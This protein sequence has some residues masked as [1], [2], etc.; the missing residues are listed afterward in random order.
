VRCCQAAANV[1][2]IAASALT[3]GTLRPVAASPAASSDAASLLM[4][5]R[6]TGKFGV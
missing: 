4:L 6:K 3:P 1:A 5:V 2:L